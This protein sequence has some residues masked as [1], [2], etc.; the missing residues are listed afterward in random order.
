MCP[1]DALL[2]VNLVHHLRE[3]RHGR[4]VQQGLKMRPDA[5]RGIARGAPLQ[6][7]SQSSWARSSRFAVDAAR[8]SADRHSVEL[9]FGQT[10]ARAWSI[11]SDAA[12]TLRPL[13]V[14]RMPDPCRRRSKWAYRRRQL[15][16]RHRGEASGGQRL[17]SR[18]PRSELTACIGRAPTPAPCRHALEV[19]PGRRTARRTPGRSGRRADAFPWV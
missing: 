14:S 16:S 3:Q 15:V 7:A 17:R 2:G 12:V 11:N 6:V 13:R 8:S 19:A 4:L 1:L 10:S 5:L 18:S 9:S